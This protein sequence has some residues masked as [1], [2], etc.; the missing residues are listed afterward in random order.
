MTVRLL[1]LCLLAIQVEAA[2]TYYAATNGVT[3]NDGLSTGAPWPYRYALANA[4]PSNT[5]VAMDGLYVENT[6]L[7]KPSLHNGLTIR[8][9]NKWAAK[10]QGVSGDYAFWV[11]YSVSNVVIDGVQVVSSWNDDV[12]FGGSDNTVQNCWLHDAGHGD[13]SWVTNTTASYSG[14]GGNILPFSSNCIVQYS[15]IEPNGAWLDHDHGIYL[16]GTN[17]TI[18]GNVLRY[19][20]AYGLQA[21]VNPPSEVIG[22]QA[23]NNLIYGNGNGNAQNAGK[24]CVVIWTT[25]AAGVNYFYNN[26][27]QNNNA[28]PAIDVHGG[29][30]Y[31]TNNIILCSYLSG[32]WAEDSSVVYADYNLLTNSVLG[33]GGAIDGG[34]NI[35]AKGFG[36][37]DTTK[38][39]WWAGVSSPARGQAVNQPVPVD[40]FGNAQ[41]SIT[42]IGPFQYSAPYG[43]DTRTLDPS[44]PG[45]AD[46]WAVLSTPMNTIYY[47]A[48][49]GSSSNNGLS[50]N[51]PWPLD[52][53]LLNAGTSNIVFVLPGLYTWSTNLTISSNYL[54]VVSSVKWGATITNVTV[55][56]PFYF[57]SGTHDFTL[58]GFAFLNNQYDVYGGAVDGTSSNNVVRNCWF[59]GTG[60]GF[61][62]SWSASGIEV[63]GNNMLVEKC[64]SEW[65]GTNNIGYNH[66]LYMGGAGNIFRNNVLRYNGGS[67]IML[68]GHG[69]LKDDDNQIYNNLCYANLSKGYQISISSDSP[70]N[71]GT[72]YVYGNTLYEPANSYAIFDDSDTYVCIT[73][74]IILAQGNYGVYFNL[75]TNVFLDYNASINGLHWRVTGPH[76]V[77]TNSIGFV[78]TN[79]GLYWLAS[80]ATVRGKALSA[81]HGPVDFF[82][83]VQSSVSDIGAFQYRN[84]YANDS[85]TLDPSPA[86]GADYWTNL[87]DALPVIAPPLITANPRSQS[88]I[89]GGNVTFTVG[90]AGTPPLEY[91]W[92]WIAGAGVTNTDPAWTNSALTLDDVQATNAGN[93]YAVVSDLGGAISSAIATLTVSSPPV[94]RSQPQDDFCTNGLVAFYPFNGNQRDESGNGND[95]TVVGSDWEYFTDRFGQQ[96]SLF[97]NLTSSPAWNSDGTY[98]QMPRSPSFAFNNDFTLSLWVNLTGGTPPNYVHNLMSNGPDSACANLR[99]ISDVAGQEGYD[100]LEFVCVWSLGTGGGATYF[101]PSATQT[102]R[103]IIVVHSRANLSLYENGSFLSSVGMTTV[104]NSPTIWLGRH[105]CAG[106]P[107]TCPGSYPLVG[108]IDDVRMYNR[109]LSDQEIS[110]LYEREAS[111]FGTTAETIRLSLFVAPGVTY[112]LESSTDL[113]TWSAYGLSFVGTTN[114]ITYQDVDTLGSQQF[115]R[116]R[117]VQ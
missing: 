40:F 31:C 43:G 49:N 103:Q 112:Q 72:N 99:I 52:Y 38:G 10:F 26:I 25:S 71:S 35:V 76:D 81:A 30:L 36:F 83:N 65:N 9:Q 41:S 74:N 20:L 96:N 62:P 116:V 22:L 80:E 105:I 4:G 68:N 69:T 77:R 102:W 90:A 18:R 101:L 97:L 64:L 93:F 1:I 12:K 2:T 11:D 104:S 82:G 94:I 39:L 13:P 87:V 15:L 54:T 85:R 73:N 17:H 58:D 107:T 66:G 27:V 100:L 42:D 115:F 55:Y 88:V 6:R 86:S 7:T 67:G 57:T 37:V 8:A 23:Y 33:G 61:T 106:C 70:G 75:T 14:Q 3:S 63:L 21:Y 56:H 59:K 79:S 50:T 95:G 113:K 34:H 60:N 48:T 110:R 32:I 98:V 53:A 108:G 46:Y 28:F 45:G 29:I 91:Q 89:A 19:N 117:L 111:P 51:A 5:V 92:W 16:G 24:N 47:T 114:S 44:P 109:A 78:N 84:V